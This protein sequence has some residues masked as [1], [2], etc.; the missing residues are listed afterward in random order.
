MQL[1]N[2]HAAFR[3]RERERSRAVGAR[4]VLGKG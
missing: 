2:V 4:L 1:A 3:E